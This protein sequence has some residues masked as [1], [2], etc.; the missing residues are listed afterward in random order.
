MENVEKQLSILR[1][2]ELK[3]IIPLSRSTIWRKVKAGE[4]PMPLALGK[5][6]VGWRLSEVRAWIEAQAATRHRGRQ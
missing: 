4:F 3:Q 5:A 6:A 1:F 2:R